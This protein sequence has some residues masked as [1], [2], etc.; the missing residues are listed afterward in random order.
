[1][2]ADHEQRRIDCTT[3]TLLVRKFTSAPVKALCSSFQF[4]MF[5][6]SNPLGIMLSEN[7][8]LTILVL[9]ENVE[10]TILV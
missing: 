2:R 7:V 10:L 8:E 9:S 4:I 6:V 1:M 5:S 3:D